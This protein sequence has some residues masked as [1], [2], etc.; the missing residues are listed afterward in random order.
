[1]DDFT[2]FQTIPSGAILLASES[3]QADYID[4]LYTLPKKVFEITNSPG[5]GAY[6]RGL[7]KTY[8]TPESNVPMIAFLTLQVMIGEKSLAQLPSMLSTDLRL[9]N[10]KAQ[11]MAKEIEKE[12]FAPVMLELNQYLENRKKKIETSRP[13]GGA[14]NVLN[15]K[16][17]PRKPVPPPIPK[18]Q[19]DELGIPTL[20][21]GF[22]RRGRSLASPQKPTPKPP[23]PPRSLNPPKP[24][25]TRDKGFFLG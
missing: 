21:P 22:A 17:Q 19:N 4:R 5:T 3:E 15:L 13:T 25:Q 12:L 2:S 14:T 1:M 20:P 8:N 16:E 23:L 10:D 18:K 6:L 7:G 11:A 24:G 9:P